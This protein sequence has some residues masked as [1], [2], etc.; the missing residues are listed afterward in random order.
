ML[1]KTKKIPETE[2]VKLPLIENVIEKP[3]PENKLIKLTPIP[4]LGK[5]K[6]IFEIELVK[7]PSNKLPELVKLTPI[8]MLGKTKKI[9]ERELV[10]LP[11]IEK[12]TEL[13]KLPSIENAIEKPTEL[14]KL[15]SIEN[16]IEKP[17]QIVIDLTDHN[18]NNQYIHELQFAP[19]S[20]KNPRIK[21]DSVPAITTHKV[22]TIHTETCC[23]CYDKDIPST[24]LL[25]CKHPV[26]GE[27]TEQLQKPEC[28]LCKRFLEGPLV[29]DEI[30]AN[31]I[32]RQEQ[33][34]LQEITTNYLVGLYLE[35][36]PDANPEDV[37]GMYR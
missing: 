2:L 7:L 20:P 12:P 8:P 21:T 10:K 27:C 16:V 15:P 29:T 1:G 30:L 14:V 22:S 19:L 28:P 5:T 3:I 18:I 36:H 34:R 13:V 4:M 35:E 37:Y 33:E 32:N 31:L 11:S 9:P 25:T 6:K 24:E 26:C 17:I 23:I